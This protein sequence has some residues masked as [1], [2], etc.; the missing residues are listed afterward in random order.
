MRGA[1]ER[2]FLG[3]SAFAWGGGSE[4]RL[5]A[6]SERMFRGASD[7]LGGSEGRLGGSEVRLEPS[8]ESIPEDASGRYPKLEG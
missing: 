4:S 3:A 7:R 1:S 6:G 2:R 8:G 5:A